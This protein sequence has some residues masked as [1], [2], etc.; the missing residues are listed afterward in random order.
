M[1]PLIPLLLVCLC[2]SI[3]ESRW[4]RA[5]RPV[6]RVQERR[7]PSITKSILRPRGH[8]WNYPQQNRLSRFPDW[9]NSQQKTKKNSRWDGKQFV[10]QDNR[11]SP[12]FGLQPPDQG[13]SAPRELP[14]PSQ[15][16][17]IPHTHPE[18]ASQGQGWPRPVPHHTR[19]PGIQHQ[20]DP[21]LLH[22]STP[23][24]TVSNSITNYPPINPHKP[25]NYSPIVAHSLPQ[26]TPKQNVPV[27]SK[28]ISSLPSSI[29]R[30]DTGVVEDGELAETQ[31][32]PDISLSGLTIYKFRGEDGIPGYIPP[33]NLPIQ[34][35]Q[36]ALPPPSKPQTPAAPTSL[37][38]SN[39]THTELSI[40]VENT[41]EGPAPPFPT[42]HTTRRPDQEREPV[43]IIAQSSVMKN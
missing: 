27:P 26:A 28:P 21:A 15:P 5:A 41:P 3:T 4:P 25:P 30:I 20:S 16:S 22:Q 6:A 1:V 19:H 14:G 35:S 31:E 43:V 13:R 40:P 32:I 12:L 29:R 10:L 38:L 17:Q 8:R 36:A 18:G 37:E 11:W 2:S 7:I 23:L 33:A 24:S 39:P 42:R 34:W 9:R